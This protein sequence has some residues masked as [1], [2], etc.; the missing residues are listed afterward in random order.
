MK[1]L[2]FILFLFS[3]LPVSQAQVNQKPRE[4]E[5]IDILDK[6]GSKVPLDLTF[7]DEAG[8]DVTLGQYFHQGK[9]VALV[10]AYYE[11]PM[12][13][14]FV[15]NALSENVS[16]IS[17]WKAGKEFQIVTVSI[18]PKETPEMAQEKKKNYLA[19]IQMPPDSKGWAF[20]TDPY[21]NSKKLADAVGFQYYYDEKIEQYAHPAVTFILTEDGVLSRDLFGLTYET[22]DLKL[23]FLEASKG[24]IGNMIEKIL[25]FCYHYDPD[26]KGYVLFAQNVMKVGGILTVLALSAFLGIFW[27][28]DVKKTRDDEHHETIGKI[29]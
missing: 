2:L 27:K 5:N 1:K 29:V 26:A 15:L 24:K 10:L 19:T 12:L 20:L 18:D 6:L 3:A 28:M 7:K 13:C 14:T 4:L 23:A 22:K 11:C 21:N 8:N 25:L 9:P 16:K 17:N